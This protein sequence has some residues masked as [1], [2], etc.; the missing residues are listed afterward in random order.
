MAVLTISRELGSGG[1]EIAL[2]VAKSLGHEVV[3]KER[4]LADMRAHG[5]QWEQWSKDLDEHAPSTWEKYD[6]SFRGFVAL[7]QSILFKYALRD[8]VVL[9]GRGANFLMKDIPYAL[10][11]RIT[12]PIESRISRIMVRESVNENTALW[13]IDKSDRERSGFIHSIY[14]KD[15]NDPLEYDQIFDTGSKPLDEVVERLVELLREWDGLCD[16]ECRE[17]IRMRGEAARIKAGLLT[18]PRLF[19]PTLD[20]EFDGTGIAL[21]GVIHNPREYEQVEREA[22]KLAGDLPLRCQLHYRR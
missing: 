14:G 11:A 21:R 2:A 12:A 9:L 22:R 18:N 6:W 7:I 20:V 4:L 19:I 8:R 5:Q 15:W 3:D 1:R 17:P 16:E 13:L 10:R